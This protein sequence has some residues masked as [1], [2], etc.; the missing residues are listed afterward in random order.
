MHE[1]LRGPGLTVVSSEPLHE[2]SRF[3]NVD[4]VDEGF[5]THNLED[6]VP[7]VQITYRHRHQASPRVSHESRGSFVSE[8]P[9]RD[10]I[11]PPCPSQKNACC[12]L[13]L[14]LP[15]SSP[16]SDPGSRTRPTAHPHKTKFSLHRFVRTAPCLI[17]P[18][19]MWRSQSARLTF[20]AEPATTRVNSRRR[21]PD[22]VCSPSHSQSRVRG[23]RRRR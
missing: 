22:P 4:N 13:G 6:C 12:Q 23:W 10:N 11:L 7:P 19:G 5:K 18:S 20:I 3:M 21:N 16:S 8:A 1:T 14:E 17:P 9:A 2:K 15:E